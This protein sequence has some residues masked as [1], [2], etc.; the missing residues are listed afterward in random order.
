MNFEN[1]HFA[2]QA[3]KPRI[4]SKAWIEFKFT[5]EPDEDGGIFIVMTDPV[6]PVQCG[7]VLHKSSTFNHPPGILTPLESRGEI[8]L[9]LA[10]FTL[11]KLVRPLTWFNLVCFWPKNMYVCLEGKCTFIQED[12]LLF[13]F[14]QKLL[15]FV[16]VVD[17]TQCPPRALHLALWIDSRTTEKQKH[18]Q[19]SRSRHWGPRTPLKQLTPNWMSL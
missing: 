11:R 9:T 16:S 2:S 7:V 14:F 5:P 17:Q 6:A 1:L 13:R 4:V 3:F 8:G 18:H 15:S 10:Q 19:V 12:I